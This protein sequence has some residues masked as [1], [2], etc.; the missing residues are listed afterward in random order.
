MWKEDAILPFFLCRTMGTIQ[1]VRYLFMDKEL[2]K[3]VIIDPHP[4]H[5]ELY[6]ARLGT[7]FRYDDY[8]ESAAAVEHLSAK[9]DDAA[10]VIVGDDIADPD[11]IQLIMM[12]RKNCSCHADAVLMMKEVSAANM[13]RGYQQGYDLVLSEDMNEEAF[14]NIIANRL[15][16]AQQIEEA[17]QNFAGYSQ[18][19]ERGNALVI[20]ILTHAVYEKPGR[21]KRHLCSSV[22][23][24]I[25][26]CRKFR[27]TGNITV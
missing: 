5:H 1:S 12:L 2:R 21:R 6:H 10:M 9:N 11:P 23:F 13:N 19:H 25:R 24:S 17:E 26:S 22:L 14:T 20:N 15:M 18:V 4:A 27:N 3:I 7:G 16:R 8:T